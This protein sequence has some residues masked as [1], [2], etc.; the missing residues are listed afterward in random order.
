MPNHPEVLLMQVSISSLFHQLNKI[1]EQLNAGEFEL[2]L[3]EAVSFHQLLAEFFKQH[4]P[5]QSQ[6]QELRQLSEKLNSKIA[7]FQKKQIGIQKQVAAIPEVGSNKVSKTY[8][9]E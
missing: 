4:Q 2:A 8:L 5:D 9:S 3:N 6:T 7:E 1:D